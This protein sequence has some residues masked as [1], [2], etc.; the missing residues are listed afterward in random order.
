MNKISALFTA[1]SAIIYSPVYAAAENDASVAETDMEVIEVYAQ[2]RAQQ[3]A[4]VPI[5]VTVITNKELARSNLKDA[6]ELGR[7]SANLKISQNAAEGT[8]PAINIRGVGLIDYNTANTSP[9]AMYVDGLPVG[10]ANNQLV[11]LYDVQ[12]VEVLKGPQGTLFGRNST[13][14]AILIRSVRPEFNDSGYIRAD[15]GSD[16]YRALEGA[17]NLMLSDKVAA[18][19]A[20]SHNRYDYTTENTF[21]A[22]PTA[23]MEQNN[24]RLGI[25]VVNDDSDLYVQA[26]FSHWNGIVQPVGSI[27]VI[28]DPLSGAR[29]S[30]ELAGSSQC[31]DSFGFNDGSDDFWQVSVNNDSPHHTAANGIKANYQWHVDEDTDLVFL[32]QFSQLDRLHHFNCDG[33]PA[34]LCEGYLGLETKLVSNELQWQQNSASGF[35]TLGAYH[36]FEQIKQDNLNDILHDFRGMLPAT[37][38]AT[39]LYDNRIDSEELALF[40]QYEWRV[41]D[42][43]VL[44]FGL[45]YSHESFDYDSVTQL[46]VVAD[47]TQ[48][49]GI[50]IPFYQVDGAVTDNNV[51]GKFAWHRKWSATLDSYYSFSNGVKSGGYNGGFLSSLEQAELAEYG[52]EKLNAH[53][54]GLK[55]H[56]PSGELTANMAAFYYDYRDQQVF[57]NQPSSVAG[58]VPLQLLK[59]VGNSTISGA[60]LEVYYQPTAALSTKLLIGYIPDAEFDEY[61]DP[62]GVILTDKRLPFTSKWNASAELHYQLTA[63]PVSLTLGL[64]YQS[65]YYFDQNENPYAMQAGYTLWHGQMAYQGKNWSLSVWG[66]NLFDQ[67]YSH[68]KFDLS[69]FL[70]MLEDFKGEGRR[71]GASFKLAF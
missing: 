13:G 19:V 52:P 36:Q 22:A 59:N 35:L 57:M 8:T 30:P 54:V 6:T 12:Q 18:R 50:W 51:S 17:A 32:S 63:L 3:N 45:R 34:N 24:G 21:V 58:Q 49:A 11:N 62:A 41:T 2:K 66:K 44:L 25:K 47:A 60:E 37:L 53:E 10:S 4:D 64:D 68:L 38:T 14:G 23:G 69:N 26:Y 15:V 56:A 71:F 39:F 67:E 55:Y 20:L 7:F 9:I 27:G 29:C 16:A 65:E 46:N 1:I 33:S 61:I 5:S 42:N 48:L 28:A 43:D 40:G 31:Y 70:G